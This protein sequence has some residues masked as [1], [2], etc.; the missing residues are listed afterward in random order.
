VL[1][2]QQGV[3]GSGARYEGKVAGKTYQWLTKA[4]QGTLI[5]ADA[6]DAAGGTEQITSCGAG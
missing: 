5:V 1:L 3:S 2:L 6:D 4:E